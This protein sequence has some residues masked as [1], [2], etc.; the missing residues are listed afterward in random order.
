[1]FL[2][3]RVSLTVA[4]S[5]KSVAG[6]KPIPYINNMKQLS[7]T[8]FKPMKTVFNNLP[9]VQTEHNLYIY[10]YVH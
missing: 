10:Q 4:T 3:N 5:D 2:R 6:L 8:L 7:P 9:I 1:M